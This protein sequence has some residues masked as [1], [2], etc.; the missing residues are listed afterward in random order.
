MSALARS[1]FP[2]LLLRTTTIFSRRE[3]DVHHSPG[4][5][6]SIPFPLFPAAFPGRSPAIDKLA[7]LRCFPVFCLSCFRGRF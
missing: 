4:R 1:P 5:F 3:R 7:V 2:S 6:D